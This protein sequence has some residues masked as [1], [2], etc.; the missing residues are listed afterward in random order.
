MIQM[1]QSHSSSIWS[2]ALHESLPLLIAGGNDGSAKIWNT[3]ECK[4]LHPPQSETIERAYSLCRKQSLHSLQMFKVPLEQIQFSSNHEHNVKQVLC[5]IEVTMIKDSTSVLLATRSGSVMSLN[6]SKQQWT[7]HPTWKLNLNKDERALVGECIASFV[8]A[9]VV[10][11]GCCSGDVVLS[12]LHHSCR[13]L[14][15]ATEQ[16]LRGIKKMK[17]VKDE[18][19]INLI[20]CHIKGTVSVVGFSYTEMIYFH[21]KDPNILFKRKLLMNTVGVPISLSYSSELLFVGDTRGNVAFFSKVFDFN[22]TPSKT[23]EDKVDK[24]HGREHVTAIS[25][26]KNNR[27]YSVGADGCLVA[28]IIDSTNRKLQKILTYPMRTFASLVAKFMVVRVSRR[29]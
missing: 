7:Q 17:W 20:S 2:I 21:K 15:F 23:F 18:S 13:H 10:A 16:C 24:A 8:P 9:Q 4:Y 27:V 22:S 5:G 29:T 25:A 11:V 26:G 12:S 6:L 19:T 3:K 14:S 28:Y 1:I